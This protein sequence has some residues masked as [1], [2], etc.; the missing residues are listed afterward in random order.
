MP[1]NGHSAPSPSLP[2]WLLLRL[3]PG[4]SGDLRQL[5]ANAESLAEL[6]EEVDSVVAIPPGALEGS[7]F[8]CVKLTVEI[9][10]DGSGQ[11]LTEM[12]ARSKEMD[13]KRSRN[14]ASSLHTR[15]TAVLAI[16][17]TFLAAAAISY[18]AAYW[19]AI[20]ALFT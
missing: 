1:P 6:D 12:E 3:A 15:Y 9:P 4:S 20:H 8:S 10:T 11:A 17:G 7:S 13:V 5:K 14:C 18:G 19:S 16:G 2:V